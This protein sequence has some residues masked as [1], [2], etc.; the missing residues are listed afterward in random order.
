MLGMFFFIALYFL[1]FTSY[2]KKQNVI[3]V[4]ESN[5]GFL[6]L[7]PGSKGMIDTIYV[8]PGDRVQVGDKMFSVRTEH[9]S[10][11]DASSYASKQ[12]NLNAQLVKLSEQLDSLEEKVRLKINEF[13][14]KKIR[15]SKEI[16]SLQE[17]IELYKKRESLIAKELE[18][19]EILVSKG[20]ISAHAYSQKHVEFIDAKVQRA[21]QEQVFLELSMTSENLE[22]N[23]EL[24]ITNL[25]IDIQNVELKIKNIESQLSDV[26]AKFSYDVVSSV[27][28]RVLD[29]QGNQGELVSDSLCVV[30]I[31][32]EGIQL[33]AKLFIPSSSKGF[34]AS[35][36]NVKISYVA[37]PYT[38]YG[39][40]NATLTHVGSTVFKPAEIKSAVNLPDDHY[41]IANAVLESNAIKIN[42]Q[43]VDVQAGMEFNANVILDEKTIAQWLF[44]P[45]I[46]SFLNL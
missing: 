18:G 5:K 39:R 25:R 28:G 17:V 46:N 27:N 14:L 10:T 24:D 44:L 35:G 32:P 29:V 12:S 40:F 9:F 4:I 8:A 43:Y 13:N 26:A 16:E 45:I 1:C 19:M 41:F 2:A 30:T 11:Y 34:V 20:S 36:Q 31:I 37:F 23:K 22:N 21:S 7:T 38:E 33:S 6:R 3:G 15:F 42:Q